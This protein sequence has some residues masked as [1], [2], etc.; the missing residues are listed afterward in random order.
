MERHRTCRSEA[1]KAKSEKITFGSH[2][3]GCFPGPFWASSEVPGGPSPVEA[4]VFS[5]PWWHPVMFPLRASPQLC[6]DHLR[7]PSRSPHSLMAIFFLSNLTAMTSPDLPTLSLP[8][9]VSCSITSHGLL[10]GE[11]YK[12]PVFWFWLVISQ[13]WCNHYLI[14]WV[15]KLD[16]TFF[17]YIFIF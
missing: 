2:P 4:P 16:S 7:F 15:R 6:S 3:N 12:Y 14:A 10:F 17:F 1:K 9:L 13:E 11:H 5:A 8:K